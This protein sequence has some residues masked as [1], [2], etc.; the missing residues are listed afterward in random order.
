MLELENMQVVLPLGACAL[1][2]TLLMVLT[3]KKEMNERKIPVMPYE[4]RLFS[5]KIDVFVLAYAVIV[6]VLAL[7][8]LVQHAF[9]KLVSG[10]LFAVIPIAAGFAVTKHRAGGD[11]NTE[12]R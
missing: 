4:V 8:G 11:A 10:L 6:A 3:G 5:R 9:A 7:I 2:L 1:G 12:G